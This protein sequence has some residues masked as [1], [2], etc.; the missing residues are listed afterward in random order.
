MS[1]QP[2]KNSSFLMQGAIL[3]VAGIITR[4]I[5]IAYRIP[6]TNILGEEGQGYY[7]SAFSI[8]NIALLLTSYS[9]PLAVSKLVSARIAKGERKNAFR[10]FK[11]ALFFALIVGS[12]VA[13]V[14]FLFADFIAEHMMSL[15]LSVYALKV[16]A[17]GL[18]IVAVMGVIR[19]FFQGMGTM[20]PTAISQILEQIVN[21]IISIIGASYLLKMGREAAMS[22]GNSSVAYAY[23]AAGG[24]LGT[25]SG[26]AFGV[27]FLALL[28]RVY[29]PTFKRQMLRD[30][31]RS[32]ESYG[33]IYK[34]LLLTIA[35]VILS[36]AIYNI[37]ETIDIGVF[38]NIMAAQGHTEQDVAALLGRF[39]GHYNVMI[40]IP[41]AVA[42]ALGASLIPSLTATI[43][44]NGTKKQI[45]EKINMVIRSTMMIAIP[46]FI[47]FLVLAKPILSLL[48]SGDMTLSARLLQLGAITT[49]FFCLSTVTNAI[50]QGLNRMTTPVKHA[51]ISLVVHLIGVFVMLIMFK[52]G[53]FALVV[54]NIIFSLCM[55]ILNARALRRAVSYRQEIRRTFIIPG[56]AAGIMGIVAYGSYKLMFLLL[57]SGLSV[58]IALFIAVVVYGVCLLKLGAFHASEILGFPK[59][60][61]ILLLLQ[62]LHL[63]EKEEHDET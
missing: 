37:N 25:V 33:Q 46:S 62:R 19:G 1:T 23:G 9:L 34:V 22:Q 61:K 4:L 48:F 63:M 45:H 57:P 26:A 27:L 16:L 55:C 12:L 59:G 42:N 50:L 60:N 53:I 14:V 13:S 2:K 58:L 38:G 6:V 20:V 51:A 7:G 47:G 30:H 18:L 56:M 44:N 35:P 54:G 3:A 15:R 41:V 21:A 24:T 5:G 11:G 52:W 10:I 29:Y 49:V 43:A 28:F 17:P 39:S 8:Y 40:H 32:V 31:K 36:S